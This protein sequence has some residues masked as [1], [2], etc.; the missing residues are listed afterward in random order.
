MSSIPTTPSATNL[1]T[2]EGDENENEEEGNLLEELWPRETKPLL[3][4]QWDAAVAMHHFFQKEFPPG[5]FQGAR[6][7]ELGSGT[8]LVGIT[9]TLLG[10]QVVLTDLPAFLPLLRNNVTTSLSSLSA[11]D[12][13]CLP[14]PI[15][16]PL[17]E[18]LTWGQSLPLP[19]RRP[20]DYVIGS[21]ITYCKE[22]LDDLLATL[23]DPV[24][25]SLPP[26][27]P[28]LS[29]TGDTLDPS[30]PSSSSLLPCKGVVGPDTV[31]YIGHLERGDEHAF[32]ERLRQRAMEVEEVWKEDVGEG[33]VARKL[34]VHVYRSWRKTN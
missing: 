5:H 31:V 28:S 16:P 27:P 9:L 17:I 13:A 21:D 8:G 6:V 23:T 32:F 19:S 1:V 30:A 7:L 12:T 14:H 24:P 25:P 22:H 2:S 33:G 20:Y 18:P 3:N 26:L 34:W 15:L 11:S 10:A 4:Y 29:S